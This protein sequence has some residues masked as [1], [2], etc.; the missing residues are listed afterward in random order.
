MNEHTTCQGYIDIDKRVLVLETEQ[1][2]MKGDIVEI[3][4]SLKESRTLT[5]TTLITSVLGLIGIIATF[6]AR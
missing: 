5:L 4:E 1:K 2:N 6:L 3:K